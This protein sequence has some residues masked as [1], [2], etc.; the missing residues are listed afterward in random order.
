MLES[1]GH[2]PPW[3]AEVAGSAGSGRIYWRIRSG[4]VSHILLQSHPGDA[5]YG[6]FLSITR[7]LRGA[8]LA[9]P[10]IH[11]S[12]D[13]SRFVVLEDLGSIL[14]FDQ[15]RSAA[16]AGEE[17]VARLEAVYHPALA[18]L[19]RWQVLGTGCMTGCPD[20]MDRVFDLGALLWESSYFARRCA[21]ES[22]GMAPERLAE[23]T[24]LSELAHLALRVEA[25]PGVLMHRDF[26][27]QNLLS[28]PDGIWFVDY[29]GARKGSRWYD[30]ASLLWD[31][32]VALSMES[33]RRLFFRWL[34]LVPSPSPEE[35]WRDLLDAAL[36]R[37]MQALGAYGFLSRRKGLDWFARFQVPGLGILAQTL[38][39]RGNM[40]ALSSLVEELL[41]LEPVADP[42]RNFQVAGAPGE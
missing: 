19:S 7:H 27:S 30:L 21:E 4:A 37:V 2:R 13:S 5:D 39:E 29:Q 6:R 8:G 23:P 42:I 31:P 9:V 41:G 32:Y 34:E 3:R 25:H 28:R 38:A 10:E 33:R 1:L 24:L 26:Q 14:L 22:F 17:V 40:P 18:A 36:Q 35:D 12:D 20:L 15:V 11:G 16:S